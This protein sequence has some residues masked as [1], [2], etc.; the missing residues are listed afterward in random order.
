[1]DDLHSS[2]Q[3]YCSLFSPRYLEKEKRTKYCNYEIVTIKVPQHTS[4]WYS[5]FKYFFRDSHYGRRYVDCRPCYSLHGRLWNEE[6]DTRGSTTGRGVSQA[7]TLPIPL[8]LGIQVLQKKI[9]NSVPEN[10]HPQRGVLNSRPVADPGEGLGGPG[11]PYFYTKL[12]PEGPKKMFFWDRP[13]L[14]SESGWPDPSPPPLSEGL[15]PPLKTTDYS[16][17]EKVT[18]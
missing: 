16:E 15:V 5:W 6:S 7:S 10:R 13:P 11:P 12:R 8:P 17:T 1:M 3:L 14:F 4:L 2:R 18:L 9:R